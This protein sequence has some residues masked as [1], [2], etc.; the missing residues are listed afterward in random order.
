MATFRLN[1]ARI[2]GCPPPRKLAEAMDA[3]G[4]PEAEEFGVLNQTATDQSALATI[5]RRS[6]SAVQRLDNRTREVTSVAVEKVTVYPF[7]VKP[8]G[9]LLEVYAGSAAAIEQVGAFLSSCLGLA[10]V[11]ETIELDVASA[12]QKLR[13]LSQHF[14]LRSARISEYAHN[15]YMSGPYAPKFLSGEHGMEFLSEYADFV[16]AAA[17]RFDGPGGRV[18][19]TLT[20]KACFSFSCN[21]DDQPAVQTILRKLL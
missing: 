19:V 5:I 7:A 3:F 18:S 2:R 17:V 8:A 10:T 13:K 4:L 6:Q 14:V 1:L 9:E 21:D 12:L 20:P 16:A 15:S 11:V